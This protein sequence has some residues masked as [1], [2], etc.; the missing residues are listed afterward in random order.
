M[1][2]AYFISAV[3]ILGLSACKQC[4]PPPP[5][6]PFKGTSYQ[7]S[8]ERTEESA[9]L[10][11]EFMAELANLPRMPLTAKGFLSFSLAYNKVTEAFTSKPI[12][13]YLSGTMNTYL[14]VTICNTYIMSCLAN[15][16]K[17][18]EYEELLYEQFKILT[19]WTQTYS[20][21]EDPAPLPGCKPP[22]VRCSGEQVEAFFQE[23]LEA[24]TSSTDKDYWTKRRDLCRIYIS[25]CQNR[26]DC[27]ACMLDLVQ[28]V[29]EQYANH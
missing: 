15:G 19:N 10:A 9:K 25:D 29:R 8:N 17:K 4:P 22:P 13:V 7:K 2:N 21:G 1:K 18:H 27:H 24:A 12:D 26:S 16:N 20:T 3:L 23:K 6:C 28:D 11:N 5:E 14:E